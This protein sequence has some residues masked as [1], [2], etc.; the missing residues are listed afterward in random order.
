[1]MG[2]SAL[3]KGLAVP[4]FTVSKTYPAPAAEVFALFTDFDQ[5]PSRV[6]G[7]TRVERLT[8][9]PAGVGTK[10]KET[11]IVFKKEA[12]ETFEVTVFEPPARFE[13]VAQSCGA[14]Y[15]ADHRF[16]PDGAG[17]RVDVTMTTRAVSLYA[18]LFSP[19]AFLMVRMMKKCLIADLDQM[20]AALAGKAA[21]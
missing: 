2:P 18:K 10:F 5:L 16:T 14:E 20:E 8:A 4:T 19:L 13:M 6:N 7:I 21:T 3:V 1:M 11:R 12:T 15:R 17:T 9:G